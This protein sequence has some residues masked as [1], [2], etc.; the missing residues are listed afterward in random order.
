MSALSAPP[1]QSPKRPEIVTRL[2]EL[3]DEVKKRDEG[4]YAEFL[5]QVEESQQN[6]LVNQHV[7]A[8]QCSYTVIALDAPK[9]AENSSLR[10][11]FDFYAKLQ[12]P[13]QQLATNNVTYEL[14]RFANETL[15]FHEL[16]VWMRDFLVVP[17]ILTKAELRFLWRMTSLQW[18]RMGKD[19]IK[20]LTF[21]MFLDFFSRMAILAYNKP[22]MRRL[23]LN[24]NGTMPPA[25]DLVEILCHYMHLDDFTWVKERLNTVGR[26]S[27]RNHNFRSKG[28]RNEAAKGELRD[29]VKG[30]RFSQMMSEKTE[31]EGEGEGGKEGG[32]ESPKKATDDDPPPPKLSQADR[33]A[34]AMNKKLNGLSRGDEESVEPEVKPQKRLFGGD[35]SGGIGA[36]VAA[37]ISNSLKISDAQEQ[38]L[39]DFDP[40]LI[41]ILEKYSLKQERLG[42]QNEDS[43]SGG[44]FLDMGRCRIGTSCVIHID[45]VNTSSHEMQIDVI[46]RGFP[47]ENTKCTLLAKS[48]APGLRREATVQFT[49]NESTTFGDIIAHIDVHALP[50]RGIPGEMPVFH[51]C[52]VFMRPHGIAPPVVDLPIANVR[53]LN[54][55][56]GRFVGYRTANVVDF[57]KKGS[58]YSGAKWREGPELPVTPGTHKAR[59]AYQPTKARISVGGTTAPLPALLSPDPREEKVMP[60]CTRGLLR[61]ATSGL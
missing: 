1:V 29:D 14:M 38:A 28:E 58:W 22:G 61:P 54:E 49:V 6:C 13:G 55:L 24:A 42:F 53:N 46:A 43:F 45:V 18:V 7:C 4:T 12:T 11:A 47:C 50:V 56:I 30:A 36:A 25:K 17:T 15:S 59:T 57:E 9:N 48:F 31:K 52:P 33:L 60:G 51:R 23:I 20:Y 27:V 44:A 10:T 26:E 37:N 39:M 5:R 34:L 16:A 19:Q 21:E 35:T 3:K 41:K 40:E 8:I 32:K 2:L